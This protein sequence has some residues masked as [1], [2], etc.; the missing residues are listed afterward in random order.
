M[1]ITS[2]ITGTVALSN[3]ISS[4]WC[5]SWESTR[6]TDWGTSWLIVNSIR[7]FEGW[8]T[9]SRFSDLSLRSRQP[10]S[11]FQYNDNGDGARDARD[12]IDHS[13]ADSS[14]MNLMKCNLHQC[15]SKFISS[16][17]KSHQF[18][19]SVD[20]DSQLVLLRFE[21]K[22]SRSL[23][24]HEV[25]YFAILLKTGNQASFTWDWRD[26]SLHHISDGVYRNK[27]RE[28]E[29][30]SGKSA[31]YAR[32]LSID[33]PELAATSMWF[34]MSWWPS[35]WCHTIVQ[36]EFAIEWIWLVI[37]LSTDELIGN[38]IMQ[39]GIEC[40]SSL[41]D[42]KDWPRQKRFPHNSSISHHR[43]EAELHKVSGLRFGVTV[44]VQEIDAWTMRL[45]SVGSELRY[46]RLV[47]IIIVWLWRM[48]NGQ[49]SLRQFH[50]RVSVQETDWGMRVCSRCWFVKLDRG[51]SDRQCELWVRKV[52]PVLVPQ[53]NGSHHHQF[54]LYASADKQS[55]PGS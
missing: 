15:L 46:H 30:D 40:D 21:A 29:N 18:S 38:I 28:D 53:Q 42:L 5:S 22:Q 27:C 6:Q 36:F 39:F 31:Q 23:R 35:F 44:K 47:S 13:S 32:A 4:P 25:R 16:L 8:Q 45:V 17:W 11:L 52:S 12:N 26:G 54:R 48:T 2:S 33:R 49:N 7:Y 3:I 9:E 37:F 50:I 14:E 1:G 20:D 55:I 43:S 41:G 19:T 10:K 34:S 51:I 24:W